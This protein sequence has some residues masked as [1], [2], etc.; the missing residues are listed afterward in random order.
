MG[1]TSRL[2]PDR[3]NANRGTAR[4]RALLEDSLR[5]YGAGRSILADKHGNVIAGNKTLETA[6]DLGLPV[7]FVE[8]D[9]RELVVVQRRDL[10]LESDPR[11]RELAYADNR[12]AELDLDWDVARLLADRDAGL[13]LAAVGFTED[14][15]AALLVG[16]DEGT[17]GLTDPDAVPAVPAEPITRRGDLWLLGRHRLLCGDSTVATDVERLFGADRAEMV[18]TDPPYGVAIGDKNKYLNSIARSNRV[19]KNLTN[20]TLDEDGVRQLVWDAASIAVTICTA[21]AAWYVA[22]PPGPLHLR[23]GEVLR[24]LGI[25]RQ[26]LIWAK[27][28][29]TFAPFGVSYHWAH[30]P[31]FYG[32]LPNGGHRYHGDRKQTTLWAIDRPVASP[33]HPTMKPIELVTRA[34]EHSSRH[35]EIVYDPFLG[36]GTTMIASEQLGRICYGCEIDSHYCDVIVQRWQD[37]TGQ[38]AR[39]G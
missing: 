15:L 29:A 36:S 8:T 28:N 22:A 34:L 33:E 19:E 6:V 30:E 18:W 21:G 37:F 11:A 3:R 17:E 27:N 12:V 26:T 20:D 14:E 2:Q 23:F 31:I 16:L 32:W 1:A 35:G 24:D 7:R 4:G 10:D 25:Y 38:E 5:R 9:G 13:D 39:R